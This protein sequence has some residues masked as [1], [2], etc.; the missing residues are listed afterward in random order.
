MKMNIQRATTAV[1]GFLFSMVVLAPA[2]AQSKDNLVGDVAGNIATTT[3]CVSPVLQGVGAAA[4]SLGGNAAKLAKNTRGAGNAVGWVS[5]VATAVQVGNDVINCYQT[6]EDQRSLSSG[7]C[8]DL[9]KD[10]IS[11][12]LH[13]CVP[14]IA[15]VVDVVDPLY[16]Q[17]DD[18][19]RTLS[20][21]MSD[22]ILPDEK[23]PADDYAARAQA[24]RQHFDKT[25][26]AQIEENERQSAIREA[27]R[28]SAIADP[29]MGDDVFL[30][31]LTSL[32]M[33]VLQG[34]QSNYGYDAKCV[35]N[36]AAVGCMYHT[37]SY[38]PTPIQQNPPASNQPPPAPA[39]HGICPY[40]PIQCGI[41]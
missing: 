29:N 14:E 4:Q 34:L 21:T 15:V 16:A 12:A 22:A 6:P 38:D 36:P 18:K 32:G 31:G 11:A 27:A 17:W 33:G 9:A 40:G 10:G 13:A 7:P 41:P 39:S 5:T 3:G 25:K 26:Q 37:G 8:R 2:M 24:A 28:N 35:N 30:S 19:G 23:N 20:D 1:F